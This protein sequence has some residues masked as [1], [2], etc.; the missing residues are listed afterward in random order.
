[1]KIYPAI[2]I[3]DGKVVR[4]RQGNFDDVTV[5]EDNPINSAEMFVNAGAKRIHI[6]D[7]DGARHGK[8]YIED[9]IREISRKYNIFIQTGG[10]IRSLDDI[11]L[12]VS[13]GANRVIIGTAAVK[14]PELVKTAVEIYGNKIAV[15]VD[16]KDNMVAV[17]GW[18]EISKVSAVDL[19][20][21]MKSYGVETIIYT[22]ISKDG[23]M[24]GANM[25]TTKE[26]IDKT[27]LKIIASGG[28]SSIKELKKAELIRAD[29]AIIGKAIYS[30][31]INI[32]EAVSMFEESC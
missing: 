10:G 25:E 1:M 3:K 19:C 21:E 16:T 6:V 17:S 18:E 22:D 11:E 13:A 28:I 4:L 20:N 9:I 29:G 12:R 8:S 15:G 27:G 26:L 2:D 5:F 7:L 14:N 31:A 32:S 23:M 30:G 24:C